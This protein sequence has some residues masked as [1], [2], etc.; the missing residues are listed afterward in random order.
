M[1]YTTWTREQLI[2]RIR[3]LEAL[4]QALLREQ[5]EETRLEF[6]WS[7][8][9]GHWYWNVK[10]NAVTFNPLKVTTLG[11]QMNEL[12]DQVTYQFFT[13]KL[14]PDD[15]QKTM[16]A[17]LDHLHGKIPVY[18][19]EYRIK[20]KDG[21]YRWYYDRGKITQH[22][23]D[24]RPAFLAGI[25]FDITDNKAIQN[26]LEQ[27]NEQLK[28]LSSIDGLTRIS[29]HR[30]LIERLKFEMS[31]SD[32]QSA[33]LSVA[34]FD[35]DNFKQVNDSYGH[36]VGDQ[37]LVSVAAALRQNVRDSD[38][39]GRFGGEEFLAIFPG[40]DLERAGRTAERIRRAIEALTTS[41]N[42]SVTVSGG[43]QYYSG[44]SA[45][46]FVH[47]ADQ[48]MYQAK[49]SGKNKIVI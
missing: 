26:E 16:D 41:D 10:S 12:P 40:T 15:Y 17:M 1:P 9:L 39:V 34:L 37:V 25:V 22:D 38:F 8:N 19:A 14:H 4:N 42:L 33:P 49:Q 24:G 47:E 20:A 27:K 28:V 29:N 23:A 36:I 13:D 32:L 21:H 46:D 7:G 45:S 2:D 6:A 11:Y 43:V 35:I 48:K 5:E 3:E 31:Q 18:E 30:S 44:Q